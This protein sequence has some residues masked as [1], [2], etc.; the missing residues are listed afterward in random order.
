MNSMRVNACNVKV[1][2]GESKEQK[3]YLRKQCQKISQIMGET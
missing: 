2:K 3:L 1:A